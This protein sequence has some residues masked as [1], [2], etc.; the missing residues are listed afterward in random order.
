MGSGS[1]LCGLNPGSDPSFGTGEKTKQ[2][3]IV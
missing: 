1:K 3:K 2:N